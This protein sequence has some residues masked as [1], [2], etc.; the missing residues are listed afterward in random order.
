MFWAEIW[1][2]IRVFYLKILIF[3]RWNVIYIWIGVF[4]DSFP[5][6]RCPHMPEDPF[7]HGAVSIEIPTQTFHF[8]MVI[9]QQRV[10]SCVGMEVTSPPSKYTLNGIAARMLI[11]ELV[12]MENMTFI[13][14]KTSRLLKLIA[15]FWKSDSL[16]LKLPITIIVVCFVIC[17]WF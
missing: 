12:H 7:S 1:K 4:A 5:R 9:L 10:R 15:W 3:W 11:I 8:R 13:C 2:D 17:L 16:T 6:F 14:S